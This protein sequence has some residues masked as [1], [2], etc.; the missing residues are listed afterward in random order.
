MKYK[1]QHF[2]ID[3]TVN[4]NRNISGIILDNGI[5]IILISDNDINKS[6]CCVGVGAGYLQDEFEGTAHF[7]EHLLFMGNEKY[8]EQN[9]YTSYVQSC[10]GSF[11]AFTADY[12]TMYYL[13]LDTS[14]F[15]KGVEMLSW[16]FKKPLLDMKHINSEMEII[17]SEH[18][19]NILDDV[20]IMD[21]IFKNFIKNGSKYKKFGTGNMKSLQGITKDDILKFYNKYYTT[22]NIYVCVI[23]S[24]P[25]DEMKDE[26]VPLFNSIENRSC[27]KSDERFEK[28]HLELNKENCIQFKSISEYNFLN[29]ILNIECNEK[30]QIEF[31]L[32]NLLNWLIGLEF[33]K[34]IIYYLKENDIIK[35]LSS[36][37]D[38]FYDYECL[39]NVKFILT[40]SKLKNF[41]HVLN[42]FNDYM[43]KI[44]DLEEE[45]FKEIYI[46]Y[47]KIKMIKSLYSERGNY[48]DISIEILENMIRGPSLN[49]SI[50]RKSYVPEYKKETYN[51]FKS[52]LKNINIK[53]TTN[54]KINKS[55]E[56]YLKSKWY[57]TKYLIFNLEFK[58]EDS[59]NSENSYDFILL[60]C[61][62]IKNF[63]IKLDIL[64][65]KYNKNTYPELK[66]TNP[67][68]NTKIYYLEDNKNDN[69][70]ANI[71][72][73][74]YNS[75]LYSSEN[76]LIVHLYKILCDEIL[77]Y[78]I[79]VISD[80]KLN[81][82]L[83]VNKGSVILN[84]Y[85]INYLINNFIQNIIKLIHPDTIFL[86]PN[87]KKYFD[88]II[89]DLLEIMQNL[90]YSS[91]YLLCKEY[92]DL[93][94]TDQML[95]QEKISFIKK[96]TLDEF[97]IKCLE[98]LKYNS[99]I[100]ILVGIDGFNI[101]RERL[102]E[103]SLR[104]I[105][106]SDIKYLVESLS[107]NPSR[108]LVYDQNTK[109]KN[110]YDLSYIFKP[111]ETNP[112]ELN[113]AIIKNYLVKKISIEY[114]NSGFIDKNFIEPILKHKIIYDIISDLINE[115]IFDQIRT[116]DKI[117][118]IV[119]CSYQVVN[120]G[121]EI[122]F[123]IYYLIQSSFSTNKIIKSI[124]KFNKFLKSDIKSNKK[125][126]MEKI[127]SLLK[128]KIL[129]YKKPFVDLSEEIDTYLE[130]FSSKIG[131]FDIYNISSKVCKKIK[132]KEIFNLLLDFFEN[133]KSGEIIFNTKNK[134]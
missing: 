16:F 125:I 8:P 118:Y 108:F 87:I 59:D 22:D 26:Y 57:D 24:K 116:I 40:D 66:Y 75:E 19:K 29:I 11:N 69:P 74:R 35:N 101:Q 4:D 111:N 83:I 104:L 5:K 115:P 32:V 30:N 124:D 123:V 88:K 61:I 100:Y 72:V 73:I 9:D 28:N 129:L 68:K 47:Q 133:Y 97:K 130:S 107:L 86:N 92:Q 76:I 121:S 102:G 64:N 71:S 63:N 13:E 109:F 42:T 131:M 96:L 94:L 82:V 122:I 25:L 36:S 90:K 15:K 70:I 99:E 10:G 38:Y 128:S 93:L 79:D 132:E 65:H 49:L 2:D 67:E 7:L 18:E 78:Y 55:T 27:L 34:S 23:D 103:E 51:L 14:F 85:G 117:G 110:K 6:I 80:Y 17:N 52:M 126:Y 77:K 120:V 54:L 56:K 119:K 33:E 91:P 48:T 53:I 20:W 50:L 37:V 43:N 112:N 98:C 62:G 134:N 41:Y 31:Q 113:N 95:P 105:S 60:N 1:F 81:F 89:S 46:N 127:K 44:L 58:Q 21:D 84:F 12:I 39:L 45:E 106:R 114:D 3:K